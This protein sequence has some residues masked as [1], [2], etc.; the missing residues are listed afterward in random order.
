MMPR[1]AEVLEPVSKFNFYAPTIPAEDRDKAPPVKHNFIETIDQ[2]PVFVGQMKKLLMTSAGNPKRD[3]DGTPI[4]QKVFCEKG[5]VRDNFTRLD[6]SSTPQEWFGAF[7]LLNIP[8]SYASGK[9]IKVKCPPLITDWC[10]F[11]NLKATLCNAGQ[12]GY[13]YS[14]WTLFTVKEMKGTLV[15][16]F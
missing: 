5:G 7:L 13:T 12:K 16:T 4:I 8:F 11:T 2:P 9:R 10:S 3:E 14:D 6:G 15:S 1:D